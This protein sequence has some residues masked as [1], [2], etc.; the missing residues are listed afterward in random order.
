L[1]IA[2]MAASAVEMVEAM[3]IVLAS[4]I[5]RG[6][7]STLEGAGL[8]LLTL[9]VLVAVFG[10]AL[11]S[12]VPI[13]VLRLVVG[14]LLLIFGLQWLRKAILRAAGYKA[15]HDEAAIF[16]RELHELAEAPARGQAQR[17]GI[18]FTVSFKGV[19]LEGLEVVVIVISF[20]V[21]AG[22]LGLAALAAAAA[23][24]VV[25]VTG[26]ILYRPLTRVPENLLKLGVGLMLT[27]FGTFWGAEGAGVRWPGGDLDILALVVFYGLATFGLVYLLGRRRAGVTEGVS[28]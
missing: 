2:V 3:T 28:S 16:E 6:W 21:S 7:R 18:A 9:A 15:L 24:L 4:G 14:L 20:G 10:P 13:E 22:R 25:G 17:D 12:F 11:V 5:T 1:I 19:L 26:L 27:S 8:A 23:A